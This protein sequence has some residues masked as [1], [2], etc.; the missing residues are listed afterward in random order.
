MIFL[1]PW[2]V[3]LM[4]S[5]Y[6]L[7]KLR[8]KEGWSHIQFAVP[9]QM[10]SWNFL[11]TRC[12]SFW[13]VRLGLNTYFHLFYFLL[14]CGLGLV[15]IFRVEQYKIHRLVSLLKRSLMFNRWF[16]AA[17]AARFLDLGLTSVGISPLLLKL[18]LQSTFSLEWLC[19]RL[20]LGKRRV[21]ISA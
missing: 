5:L 20:C 1:L 13:L 11:V 3:V 15:F 8:L 21:R 2:M 12:S 4:L 18:I 10:K 9:W 14:E 19:D 6:R 7:E 16:T 17:A